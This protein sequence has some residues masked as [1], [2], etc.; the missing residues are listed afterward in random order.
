MIKVMIVDDHHL[1]REGI[2]SLLETYEDINIVSEAQNGQE[3]VDL[4]TKDSPDVVLMD[5][6][7]PNMNGI[8]ATK[9]IME[10]N[11]GTRIIALT[12]FVEK[13]LI[14]NTLKSGA[15]GYL[16][17]NTTAD[18]LITAIRD[19]VEGQSSLSSEASNILISGY[20]KPDYKLTDREKDILSL[21]VNGLSN[22]E[23]AEDLTISPSTVKFHVSNILMKMGVSSRNKAVSLAVQEKLV[24]N[25]G[26]D[27]VNIN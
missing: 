9:K 10:S 14:E 3:A 2:R 13:E 25:A 1:V 7:M 20:K 4:I 17:K 21:M 16:M 23:I 6:K 11:P 19:S 12:S 24:D 26:P 18:K 8:D 27:T 5:I 15:I 22:N